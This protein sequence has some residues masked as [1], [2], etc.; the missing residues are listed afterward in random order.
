[1]ILRY[2]VTR[3][4]FLEYFG[5]PCWNYWPELSESLKENTTLTTLELGHNAISV[6]GPE[7]L[8]E[9]LKGNITI[10]T[11]NLAVNSIVDGA[12]VLLFVWPPEF[13]VGNNSNYSMGSCKD[14]IELLDKSHY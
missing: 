4:F 7:A 12:K 11:L 2:E 3:L 1:M 8:S 14:W 9:S 13:Q 6:D 5:C 10:T